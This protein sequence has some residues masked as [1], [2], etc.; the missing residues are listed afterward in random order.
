LDLFALSVFTRLPTLKPTSFPT[1]FPTL[2]PTRL[3]TGIPALIPNEKLFGELFEG[4]WER[5]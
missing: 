4:G 3:P 5:H 2:F 1:P